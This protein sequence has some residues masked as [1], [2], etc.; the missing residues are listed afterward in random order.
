[1]LVLIHN[2]FLIMGENIK[3]LPKRGIRRWDPQRVQIQTRKQAPPNKRWAVY[4][5]CLVIAKISPS[6]LQLITQQPLSFLHDRRQGRIRSL[7]LN[8]SLSLS[9]SSFNLSQW[10]TCKRSRLLI[11]LERGSGTSSWIL[12]SS[13]LINLLRFVW[14]GLEKLSPFVVFDSIWFGSLYVIIHQTFLDLKILSLFPMIQVLLQL[15][16]FSCPNLDKSLCYCRKK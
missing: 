1:M 14:F 10:F 16:S 9:P 6:C 8:L 13:S 2:F 7:F 11:S 5:F 4:L 3:C 12:Y 15:L